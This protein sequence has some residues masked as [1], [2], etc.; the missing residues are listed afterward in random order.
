MKRKAKQNKTS[1]LSDKQ[2]EEKK[3]R[4]LQQISGMVREHDI[5]DFLIMNWD[6]TGI[7]LVPSGNWTLEEQGTKR[8]EIAGINDKTMITATFTNTLT[9][10]FLPMHVLYTGKTSRC[11]PRFSEFPP[12]FD[13]WHSPNN[14]AN[15][16]T[17]VRFENNVIIPY[18]TRTRTKHEL[19][20]NYPALVIFEVRLSMKFMSYWKKIGFLW[21]W[22]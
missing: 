11:Y 4:F 8:V 10:H 2:F 6:Q 16:E 21:F 14:W 5:L 9:G 1:I 13:I 19:S 12:G 20:L 18:V 22:Y 15:T 7:Q 3:S 17:S